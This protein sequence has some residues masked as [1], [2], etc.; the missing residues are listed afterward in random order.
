MI[1]TTRPPYP[2][3]LTDEQWEL[4]KSYIPTPQ[5]GPNP[6]KYERR[7]I[8]NAILYIKRTGCQWRHLP[9]DFP[10]WQAVY[11]YFRQWTKMN[12]W[13]RINDDLRSRLR[14]QEGR[15]ENPTAAI[16]DSQSVKTTEA[17]GERGYDAGKKV[18]GKKRHLLVDVLGLLLCVLILPANI[19]DRDGG[20]QILETLH[21]TYPTV[22]KV[23]ADGGYQG[24]LVRRAS[25]NLNIDMEIV[26]RSDD[27]SGFTVLPRRWVVERT[28]G[29]WNRERRL[30][31]Y[32]EQ[33][34]ET[35]EAFIYITMSQLMV[36]RLCPG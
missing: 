36:R 34:I 6:V 30:S 14:V 35:G 19:Q 26:K 15:N 21:T 17:G 1:T 7:E 8:V 23:W 9:H 13:H 28:F 10:K 27:A 33:L 12:I 22:T 25:A 20:W 31:K 2:S 4:L 5:L 18:K 29:W 11:K 24:E 16:I 32:Y 3:D